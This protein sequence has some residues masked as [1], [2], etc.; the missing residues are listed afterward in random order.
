MA[1]FAPDYI[2]E[3]V[4]AITPAFLAAHGIKALVLDVD[5]TLTAHGSQ[6]LSPAVQAWLTTMRKAGIGMMIASNNVPK[7]VQPFAKRVGL[8]YEAFCVKPSPIK[9]R[10][11]RKRLGVERGELA[12]VGDQIFT[13]VLAANFYGI[14]MLLVEPMQEDHVP[15]I[16]FKRALEKPFIAHYYKKGGQRIAKNPNEQV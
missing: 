5:N 14:T 1:L 10:R 11:I 4:E 6:A 7:R 9:L 15:T 16:R 3:R 2:F 13:D 8:A 12:L